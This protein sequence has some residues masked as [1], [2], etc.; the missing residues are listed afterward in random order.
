MKEAT[1]RVEEPRFKVR[2]IAKGYSQILGVNFIDLFSP[3]VK[4]ISI[5]ALLGVVA[6]VDY[7]LEQMNVKTAFLQRELEGV[8][9]MEKHE[10]FVVSRKEDHVCYLNKSFYRLKQSPR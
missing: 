10:G 4:H 5:C 1:S 2:F 8:I 6:M 3:I 7:E 9:Y